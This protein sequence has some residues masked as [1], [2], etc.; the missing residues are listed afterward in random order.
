M[1]NAFE[2]KDKFSNIKA[3]NKR[4]SINSE[5][6]N[7]R[8]HNKMHFRIKDYFLFYFYKLFPNY[9]KQLRI[10][11]TYIGIFSIEKML[12]IRNIIKKLHEIDKL[13]LLLLSD[14]QLVIFNHL[15][16]PPIQG[17]V[18]NQIGRISLYG[19][20]KRDYITRYDEL[21]KKEDKTDIDLKLLNM[22][23]K[24]AERRKINITNI[25]SIKIQKVKFQ[26]KKKMK[27]YY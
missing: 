7:V 26:S 25:R 14:Q 1:H 9:L 4:D 27:L 10:K 18:N 15:P 23:E 6:R 5:D 17:E 11:K 22:I 13:K 16:K 21:K 19:N 12:D 24:K 3:F 8:D 2:D 20:N